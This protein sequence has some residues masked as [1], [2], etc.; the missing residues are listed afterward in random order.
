MVTE[1][2]FTGNPQGQE[3]VNFDVLNIENIPEGISLKI[4]R[5]SRVHVRH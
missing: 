3:M 2:Y 1:F 5:L 4:V